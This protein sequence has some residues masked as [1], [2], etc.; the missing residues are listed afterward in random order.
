MLKNNVQELSR[1]DQLILVVPSNR[2]RGN[3][4]KPEH[5]K[6]H[7]NRRKNYFDGYKALEQVVKRGCGFSFSGNIQSPPEHFLVQTI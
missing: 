2:T 5:R 7:M 1:W 3:E 6:Y 4:H